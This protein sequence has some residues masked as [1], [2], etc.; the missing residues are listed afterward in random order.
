MSI[1]DGKLLKFFVQIP[2]LEIDGLN[3]VIVKDRFVF[4]AAAADLEKHID[5]IGTPPN[6]PVFTW[7]GST[8]LQSHVT[9]CKSLTQVK[10]ERGK[11]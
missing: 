9:Q 4:V 10:E 11:R 1:V 3:W 8:L 7:T 2:K 6:P 5:G